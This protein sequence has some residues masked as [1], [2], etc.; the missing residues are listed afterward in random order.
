MF[1]LIQNNKIIRFRQ[2]F[3]VLFCNI[4]ADIFVGKNNILNPKNTFL[5]FEMNAVASNLKI[6]YNNLPL[7]KTLAS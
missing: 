3:V 6:S 7:T 4:D 2:I 5:S 1:L